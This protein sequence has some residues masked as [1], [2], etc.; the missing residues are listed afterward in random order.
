MN[1]QHKLRFD[2]KTEDSNVYIT[3]IETNGDIIAANGNG[4]IKIFD[5][6]CQKM[7]NFYGT[8]QK[9]ITQMYFADLEPRVLCFAAS[10][11]M[12]TL[13][14]TKE[15]K[16]MFNCE[17]TDTNNENTK[18]PI[19]S[20]ACNGH[21]IVGGTENHIYVWDVRTQKLLT[22]MEDYHSDQ[23]TKIKFHPKN[24]TNDMFSISED[25]LINQFNMQTAITNIQSDDVLTSVFPCDN[26]CVSVFFLCFHFLYFFI[27]LRFPVI[28]FVLFRFF[29]Y[30]LKVVGC[31]KTKWAVLGD[32]QCVFY[33]CNVT[34][35]L[36]CVFAFPF[37]FCAKSQFYYFFMLSW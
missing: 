23:I 14:D 35:F 9:S 16:T 32:M 26:R 33:Y 19:Y 36:S 30:F 24:Y 2:L 7:L 1:L 5:L 10:N 17:I 3:N 37:F 6:E 13:Y 27:F 20:C 34:V 11:G 15:G 22:T 28:L 18:V 21:L 8:A 29:L 25:C 12:V 4:M 31:K